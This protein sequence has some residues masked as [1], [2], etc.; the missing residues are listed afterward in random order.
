MC[1]F[2]GLLVFGFFYRMVNRWYI[3][4]RGSV[5]GLCEVWC[6]RG[7]GRGRNYFGWG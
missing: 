3:V 1:W 4:F 5:G 6:R 2:F 7:E